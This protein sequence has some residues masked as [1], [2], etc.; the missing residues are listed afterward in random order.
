MYLFFG[1]GQI[2]D[3]VNTVKPIDIAVRCGDLLGGAQMTLNCEWCASKFVEISVAPMKTPAASLRKPRFT[4]KHTITHSH[5]G[6]H[7]NCFSLEMF[8]APC[9]IYRDLI[10]PSG[11]HQVRSAYILHHTSTSMCACVRFALLYSGHGLR[12]EVY[13]KARQ[14]HI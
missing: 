9:D 7:I 12:K 6:M 13:T 5:M 3:N 4:Y 2:L 8:V 11:A 1:Q 14:L 10:S